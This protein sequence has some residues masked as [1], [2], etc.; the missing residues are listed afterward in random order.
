[1]I[2]PSALRLGHSGGPT[3]LASH[4]RLHPTS[5]M[6]PL[7]LLG[8]CCVLTPQFCWALPPWKFSAR[9]PPVLW[10]QAAMTSFEIQAE[11]VMPHCSFM[12]CLQSW[13]QVNTATACLLLILEGWV[14]LFWRVM[15]EAAGSCPRMWGVKACRSPWQR[16]PR[17]GYSFDYFLFSLLAFWV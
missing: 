15:A 16:A 8:F 4:G 6:V 5:W 14:K 10:P 2:L 17:S 13:H 1:M 3:I 7:G 9:A 11:E 12:Q